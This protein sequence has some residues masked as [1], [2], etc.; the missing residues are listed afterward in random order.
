MK[1]QGDRRQQGQTGG[2]RRRHGRRI[3]NTVLVGGSLARGVGGGGHYRRSSA[4]ALET[5]RGEGVRDL[6]GFGG[7]L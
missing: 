7:L 1:R 5:S 3:D 6:P 2:M 4:R